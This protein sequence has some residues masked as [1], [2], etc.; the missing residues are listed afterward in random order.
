[1]LYSMRINRIL[2]L[3]K[4]SFILLGPRGTGKSTLIQNTVR[5]DLEI[6]LL[7]AKDYLPLASNPSHIQKLTKSL[8]AKSWVFI[9]EI[10]KIPSLLDEV[11]SLIEKKKIN[12]ALSGSSA[13]KLRKTGA[14]LLAGRA[15]SAQLFPITYMEYRGRYTT[16]E[17]IEWGSLPKTINAPSEKADYLSSYVE[18]YLKEELIG[19]GIIRKL[20][21]F[22]RFLNTCG[23]YNA[24]ILNVDNIARECFVGRSTVQSYFEILEETLLGFRLPALGVKFNKGE[25]SHPKFYL[26]D[27]GVSRAC[28]NLAYEEMDSVWL[29]FAFESLV[30]NEVRTHNRYLKKNRDIYYYKYSGGYEIDLVIENR[31]KTLSKPQELTAIEI[32]YAKKWDKRWNDAL[33][34]FK[35]KSRA[36]CKRLIGVYRGKEELNIDGVEILPVEIFL[37]K[38]ATGNII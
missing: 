7:Q 28:S 10:Q 22:L 12:F 33:L 24:Q 37:E 31:K 9:D 27:N 11:H 17:A 20:E 16:D 1:M 19:E 32:K 35:N 5:F 3:P 29:G 26:F 21:P 38:L 25:V 18:T 23:T 30:V 4:S 2:A 8:G 6:D 36:R 13:R 15:I 34:D 14:N